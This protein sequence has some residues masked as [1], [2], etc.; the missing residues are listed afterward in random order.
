M[1]GTFLEERRMRQGEKESIYRGDIIKFGSEVVRGSGTC[2]D[3]DEEAGLD[4]FPRPIRW[5]PLGTGAAF[6]SSSDNLP[7]SFPPLQVHVSFDWTGDVPFRLPDAPKMTHEQSARNTFTVPDDDDI[8][9]DSDLE[10]IRESVCAPRLEVLIPS[11]T[12]AVP[13]SDISCAGSVSSDDDVSAAQSP[14][15]SAVQLEPISPSPMKIARSQDFSSESNHGTVLSPQPVADCIDFVEEEPATDVSPPAP[16]PTNIRSRLD[17]QDRDKVYDYAPIDMDDDITESEIES[18]DEFSDDLFEGDELELE[19][20]QSDPPQDEDQYTEEPVETENQHNWA[21]SC[22][23]QTSS[24]AGQCSFQHS[25]DKLQARST[26]ART[27]SPSDAA[28]PKT[29]APSSTSTTA[30]CSTGLVYSVPD[31]VPMTSGLHLPYSTST[32]WPCP[33]RPEWPAYCPPCAPSPLYSEGLFQSNVGM[34]I[35]DDVPATQSLYTDQASLASFVAC[36]REPEPAHVYS[37]NAPTQAHLSVPIFQ[38]AKKLSINDILDNEAQKPVS[39]PNTMSLKRKADEISGDDENE[40]LQEIDETSTETLS[41]DT[42]TTTKGLECGILKINPVGLTTPS[43]VESSNANASVAH[44]DT[45]ERPSKRARTGATMTAS[46]LAGVV[47]GSVLGSVATVA[48]LV[49]L[50]PGFF[51]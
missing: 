24:T 27:P 3:E 43:I 19:A 31:S 28:M 29:L 32:P 16:L 15:T 17:D 30:H 33:R 46:T 5:L 38:A 13:E 41:K 2:L 36:D 49:A 26:T 48:A 45:K 37:Y 18:A 47:V 1:H 12:Y 34:R 23:I 20:T 8:D 40:G 50:P 25:Q 10:I 42:N 6:T 7:E 35:D 4:C 51:A 22:S 14:D 9:D 11:R 39:K 21:P 44:V